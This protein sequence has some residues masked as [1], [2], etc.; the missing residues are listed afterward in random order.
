MK[1][2]ALSLLSFALVGALAFAE[3]A[4]PVAKITGYVNSGLLIVNT[5]D[6]M[7]YQSRA[8]DDGNP[9]VTGKVTGTIAGS[10][11]GVTSEVKLTNGAAKVGD[12]WGWL[13]L[14]VDGLKLQAGTTNSNPVGEVDDEGDGNFG[15][16]GVA[17]TYENSGFAL[18]ALVNSSATGN[19]FETDG[20]FGAKYSLDK[21]FT[22]QAFGKTGYS[23]LD[24]V[25]VTAS[26]AAVDKLT[27]T[28]GY[29]SK[30]MAHTA[31]TYIDVLGK[32][33]VTDAATAGAKIYYGLTDG[34]VI[35]K[36]GDFKLRGFGSYTIG[37]GFSASG[38]VEYQSTSNANIEPQVELDYAV[39][40]ATVKTQVVYD[41]NYTYA[42]TAAAK[43]TVETDLIF[44][45]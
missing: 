27:L 26:L 44:S 1:K 25:A 38:Y 6:G 43:T 30:T 13:A 21:M 2:V 28:A 41:T 45:F 4:A 7:T 36:S 10:N 12:N 3:D 16:N 40:G 29:N 32:Y 33:A 23:T 34:A 8:N 35:A 11:F 24:K 15:Q 39:G 42:G 20:A 22:V 9:G 37:G 14:P 5:A 17:V 31:A 19:A 18:G